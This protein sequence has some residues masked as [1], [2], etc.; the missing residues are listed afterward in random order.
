MKHILAAIGG[1]FT[2]LVIMSY[3]ATDDGIYSHRVEAPL[4]QRGVRVTSDYSVMSKLIH[5]GW[6]VTDVDIADD[7]HTDDRKYYTL[8]LY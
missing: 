3:R 4:K 7:N 6:V 8:I 2:L 5:K 1:V